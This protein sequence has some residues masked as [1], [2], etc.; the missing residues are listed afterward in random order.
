[1]VFGKKT[2]NIILFSARFLGTITIVFL[3]YMTIGELIGSNEDKSR[4]TSSSDI[5]SLLLFP[6]STIVGLL[7]AYKWEGTGGLIT[8]LGMI[9]LHILRPDLASNLLISA[10]AIPG[11]LYII[12][13]V[14]SKK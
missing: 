5:V 4:L 9:T 10:F 6:I 8:V 7:V 14:W 2:L 12:Y 13:A 11:L 1:M 3:L